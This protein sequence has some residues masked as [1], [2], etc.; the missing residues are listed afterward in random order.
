[1]AYNKQIGKIVVEEHTKLSAQQTLAF[2]FISYA[3]LKGKSYKI[4]IYE[5]II[6]EQY[7]FILPSKY[8]P[9]EN[10]RIHFHPFILDKTNTV[11]ENRIEM[12]GRDQKEAIQDI[13]E[14]ILKPDEIRIFVVE[15]VTGIGKTLWAREI[16]HRLEDM[17]QEKEMKSFKYNEKLY[18][19]S[20]K[21]D[22]A[23]INQCFN[24]WRTV[25]SQ[26]YSEIIYIY[27]Y[28]VY[29]IICLQE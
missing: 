1:M 2:Q 16:I 13:R 10:L 4:A 9:L 7:E 26:V 22:S 27:I 18:I 28:I 24:V 6:R 19:F 14:F 21:V 3:K 11:C 8:N 12:I 23:N 5:P 15:G 20:G 17:Q 29:D 25:L